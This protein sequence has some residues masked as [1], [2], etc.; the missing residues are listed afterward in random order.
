MCESV[1]LAA[2]VA[3]AT[4]SNPIENGQ[5]NSTQTWH[6]RDLCIY[7]RRIVLLRRMRPHGKFVETS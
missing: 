1:P 5:T 7:R 3:W 6:D 4:P 2:C